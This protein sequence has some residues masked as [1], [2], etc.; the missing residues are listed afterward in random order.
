MLLSLLP[1]GPGVL[2]EGKGWATVVWVAFGTQVSQFSPKA[3]CSWETTWEA[4]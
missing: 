4:A 3:G 1:E 2:Q